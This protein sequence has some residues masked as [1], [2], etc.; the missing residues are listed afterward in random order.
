MIQALV[1]DMD[2]VLIDSEPFWQ[3]V[4][5]AV[6]GALG[7]PITRADCLQT[8]GLRI[9]EVVEHWH[10]RHPWSSPDKVGVVEDIVAGVGARI[11]ERGAA[12]PGVR[13]VLEFAR[14]RGLRTA[15]ASSSRYV[16]IGAVLKAL[17]LRDA[18]EVVHSAEEEEFGKPHPAV[19][20]TAARKLG[21]PTEAC[22]AVEDSINGILSAKAAGMRC[23]A[24]PE[25]ELRGDPRLAQADLVL[26]SLE[27]LDAAAW[28]KLA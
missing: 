26:D 9:D 4:E 1:F 17:G 8:A 24:V 15:L 23:I 14:G 10:G 13:Q 5:I 19:Y 22:M 21:V 28:A 16:L 25:P 18:F 27:R 12:K 7:V 6:L 11:R 3:E 2:G 20:L